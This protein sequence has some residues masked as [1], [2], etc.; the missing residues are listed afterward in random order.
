MTDR[1]IIY[2]LGRENSDDD[3]AGTAEKFGLYNLIDSIFYDRDNPYEDL[4]YILWGPRGGG[5]TTTGVTLNILDG[6]MRGIPCISNVPFSWGAKDLNNNLYEVQSI[7]FRVEDFVVGDPHMKYKRLYVDEGNYELDRL[8]STSNKNLAMTDILQQARKFRMSVVF[9]TINWAWLDPKLTGSLCDVMIE[10]NDLYYKPAG[11]KQGLKKGEVTCWDITDQSGK[12]TGK[13]FTK[14]CSK[15]FYSKSMW[16]VF[17]TENFVDPLEARRSVKYGGLAHTIGMNEAE[18]NKGQ[19]LAEKKAQLDKLWEQNPGK[20]DDEE[21]WRALNVMEE[22]QRKELGKS[23]VKWG[24]EK[25]SK[26]S[27]KA[28][29]NLEQLVGV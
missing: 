20:W 16:G 28:K 5:K 17:D 18:F 7:P 24:I 1:K 19:W 13:P 21:L 10:C 12:F 3:P 22:G 2:S 8:R 14:I 6:Q 15:V 27:G 23:F 29:Y 26:N 4:I 25:V 11:K 9:S